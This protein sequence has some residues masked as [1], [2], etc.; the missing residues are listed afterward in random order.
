MV[1]LLHPLFASEIF[2]FYLFSRKSDVVTIVTCCFLVDL[3]TGRWGARLTSYGTLEVVGEGFENP[4]RR[5]IS[6][7]VEEDF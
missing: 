5:D 2:S 3:F 7:F 4:V 1:C 6:E